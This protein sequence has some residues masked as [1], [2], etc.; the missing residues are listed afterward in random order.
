MQIIRDSTDNDNELLTPFGRVN[1]AEK[2]RWDNLSHLRYESVAVR[3][4]LVPEETLTTTA[5]VIQSRSQLDNSRLKNEVNV[6]H[7]LAI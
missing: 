1:P 6:S 5:T 3:L 4:L 2:T 7:S